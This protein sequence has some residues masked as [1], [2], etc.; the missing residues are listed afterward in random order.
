M[1]SLPHPLMYSQKHGSHLPY[2]STAPAWYPNYS[3]H[4]AA[5]QM[6]NHILNAPTGLGSGLETDTAASFYNPHHHPMLHSSSPDWIHENYN[7]SAPNS[8]QFFANG[9]TPPSSLHLSPTINNHHST[10][11]TNASGGNENLQNGLQNIPP[12]PPSSITVNS[13]CSEMSSP[14][15]ASNGNSGVIATGDAS[16]NMTSANNLSRPKSPYEWMKKPSYQSQPSAGK[17]SQN[18]TILFRKR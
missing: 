17:Y 11:S 12:S 14:G 3:S 15:I 10:N 1:V 6:N 13:A 9:M 5:H 2:S 8:A 4:H 18:L 16:P 7:L